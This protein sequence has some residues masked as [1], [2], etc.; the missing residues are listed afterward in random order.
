MLAEGGAAALAPLVEEGAP[1]HG[2]L[3]AAPLGGAVDILGGG[4]QEGGGVGVV[5]PALLR[6]CREGQGGGLGGAVGSGTGKEVPSEGE[7]LL[8]A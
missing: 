8:Q 1:A 3:Q 5:P 7:C 4:P 2:V 6:L